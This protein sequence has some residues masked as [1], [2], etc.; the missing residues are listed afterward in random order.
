MPLGNIDIEFST[1]D[2]TYY[3]LADTN[4]LNFDDSFL[5]AHLNVRSL[6][7]KVGEVDAVIN[8]LNFPKLLLLSE[9]WLTIDAPLLN[10]DSYYFI[11]SPRMKGRGGGIAMYI[12]KSVQCVILYKSCDATSNSNID[13]LVVKLLQL[14]LV[15]CCMYC[16]PGTEAAQIVAEIDNHK[17][18]VNPLESFIVGGDFNINLLDD[19]PSLDFIS[20]VYTIGLQ[21]VITLPTRVTDNSSTLI[22]NFL[23][24][25]SLLPVSSYVLKL[26]LSDHF[27]IAVAVKRPRLSPN[28]VT[29]NFSAQNKVK[30][31]NKLAAADWTPI[32]NTTNV[33]VA[34]NYFIKKLKRIYNKCF[35]YVNRINRQ[36]KSAW[37]TSALLKSIRRKNKLFLQSKRDPSVRIK[38]IQYRNCLTKL[39]REAKMLY[40][41]TVLHDLKNNAARMWAHINS[42]IKTRTGN[43]IP[44]NADTLNDFFVSVFRQAP[45][46]DSNIGHTI[47]NTFYVN[48]SM[49]LIPVTHSE[50][51][52]CFLSL[53]NSRS[54]GAD[55][56]AP[57][58]IKANAA[59]LCDQLV[60]IFNLSFTQG[61]FPGQLKRAI[62]VP[63]Y[64][65]G[66][67][68]DPSNYRPISILTVFSKLLEKLFY[69]RL[70][71]FIDSNNVLHYNQFGFRKNKSTSLALANIISNLIHKCNSCL[72]TVFV[73]LDLKK[74]FDF[75][76]HDLLL[77]KLKH[78]G[79]RGTPL[80][81][82]TSYLTGRTQMGKVNG[83]LS[84]YQPVSAGVPQGSIL[85]PLLFILFINDVFQFQSPGV[86]IFLYADDTAIIFS[87]SD[88]VL[89]QDVVDKFFAKYV[90]WCGNNCIVV[91]PLK[92]NYLMFN[93][94]EVVITIDGKHIECVQ[95][96]KYLGVY[97]DNNLFWSYHVNHILKSCCKR[98][99]LFKKIVCFLPKFVS[100]LYY[101]AFIRSCFSYGLLFWFNNDRSGRWKLIANV[102]R[103]INSLAVKHK[104]PVHDFVCATGVCDVWK[105]HKIQ[106][107]MLMYDVI[108]GHSNVSCFHFEF[109]SLIHNHFTRGNCNIHINR[110]SS[111]DKR[112]FTYYCLLNWNECDDDMRS[113]TRHNF[114]CS[115]KRLT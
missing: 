83:S 23:C 110:V 60:Y 95:C 43:D 57:E 25:I 1:G 45:A 101:N 75:I 52:N 26:N 12:H 9:T 54:V 13:V 105:V 79:I 41:R 86:E 103:V 70:I 31:S 5:L 84:N 20:N 69:K 102:D 76:N 93:K 29:R 19:G 10:I 71:S 67:R 114:M 4:N 113:K 6:F 108:T 22:D 58:I 8:L 14:N 97:I 15:V 68:T 65:S 47:S 112:N 90:K 81:W 89:L 106:S 87:A 7:N 42:L 55:G 94:A 80:Y 77:M 27:L 62:V 74:A 21:P 98:I 46:F 73:L 63:I 2:C 37:L 64:K 16:P 35:P 100:V 24:D 3:E 38:Y 36:R 72:K 85:G 109:N 61:I 88:N 11:S 49:F 18:L 48:R 82:L 56:L 32:L 39:I 96:A 53:S 51:F 115:C 107:L 30:F 104:L 44:I 92:S 28:F 33:D 34:F 78:Y 17:S 50:V 99:G 66:V 111:L 91:N 59:L 40:H